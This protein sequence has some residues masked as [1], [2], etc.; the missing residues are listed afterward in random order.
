MSLLF[1]CRVWQEIARARA[2]ISLTTRQTPLKWCIIKSCFINDKAIISQWWQRVMRPAGFHLSKCNS[3]TFAFVAR[4]YCRRNWI[5]SSQNAIEKYSLIGLFKPSILI[6]DDQKRTGKKALPQKES[7]I[8]LWSV[9]QWLKVA[10]N[11]SL[12]SN[13]FKVSRLARARYAHDL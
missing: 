2:P 1:C 4:R 9:P 10:K 5:S 13:I 3:K 8:I 6:L 7:P 12:Y 11:I